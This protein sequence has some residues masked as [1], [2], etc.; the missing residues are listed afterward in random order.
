MVNEGDKVKI[1]S[2]TEEKEGI[3]MPSTDKDIVLLKLDSGY[4]VGFNKKDV[5]VELIEKK[6]EI[7]LKKPKL[8]ENKKLKKIA[9]LHT[10]G[11]IASKVDY[12]VGGVISHFS[13]EDLDSMFPELK[14]IAN[15]D[16]K[17]VMS[18]MSEDIMFKDYQ[19]LA[20]EIINQIK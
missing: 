1:I 20:K 15:I 11:T 18:L 7:K 3:L 19:I 16:A 10:G 9:I 6:K 5:K 12:S 8:S 13:A 2:K 4:N 17:L 14:K